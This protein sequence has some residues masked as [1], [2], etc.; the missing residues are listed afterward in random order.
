[1]T[2]PANSRNLTALLGPTNTGKTHLAV[3]RMLA[4]ES[5]MIGLPLRLL[6]REVYDRARLRAGDAAVALVTGE[7]RIVPPSPRYWICTVEAMPPGIDP[8]FLAIDEVQVSTDFERG[9]VFTDRILHRRGRVETMFLGAGTMRPI[10][11]ALLPDAN[12]VTRPRFSKLTYTGQKKLTRLPRRSAIVAFSTET[13]YALAELIRRQR[14]GAAVVL[15]ALSPRTRNAQVALYQSGDVD[16]LV[17]TDAIGMGLNM[18]VDHIAFAATRKFDGF[19]FRSLGPAELGQIA[20]RAGRYVNDGTF[21]VTADA[22]PFDQETVERL[23]NHRFEP[24]RMLQWRNRNLSFKSIDTLKASLGA[25]PDHP[26][27]AR[28]QPGSD[29]IALDLVTGEADISGFIKGPTDVE[30]LWDVCQIPD[31]RNI[32]SA[33][34]AGI[35]GRIFR[36]LGS[37]SRRIDTDWFAR[38]L[39]F[40]ERTDGDID[41]I[42]NRISHVRTW[43]F[44]ANRSGWL[45]DPVHWQNKARQ[46]EDK[47][48]DALHERLTQ[49]FIDRRT[50]VLMKRLNQRESLMST[51]EQDG[52]IHV[53]G[54]YVGHMKGFHFIPDG[55]TGS[56]HERTLKA[57]SLRAVAQEIQTRAQAVAATTDPDLTITADGQIIWQSA[58]IA[59]LEAAASILKPR[60]ALIVGD[61]L[62]GPDRDAVQLRLERWT[63]RHIGALLEPLVKLEDDED[64]AGLARGLAFRLVESLGVLPRDEV[65]EDVKSLSQEE[66][67]GLRKH[68]V[69]FGAFHIFVPALLKPAPTVLRLLLWALW[70]EKQGRF[71]RANLPQPP[72]Q[73]LTSVSFDRSTPKGFYRVV[74]FRLCG[75]RAVRMDMLERLADLIRERV[76]WRPRVEG[77]MRPHGSV[78][79]GGFTIVPDMMSLVGCSGEEFAAIL[80]S[81]GFRMLRRPVPKSQTHT[82]DSPGDAEPAHAASAHAAPA[83]AALQ[84]SPGDADPQTSEETV[85]GAS[86]ELPAA[87]A[88]TPPP[89]G[90]EPQGTEPQSTELQSAAPAPNDA[91]PDAAAREETIEVW[92]PKDTGPFRQQHHQKSRKNFHRSGKANAPDVPLAAKPHKPG[93]PQQVRKPPQ[94][95]KP[96]VNPDSPFAVLGMLRA[97]L[98]E[99]KNA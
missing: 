36:F 99:K 12:F 90:A 94:P 86:P 88:S 83:H 9:H 19:G 4:H 56:A 72:G 10:L 91:A 76:F 33:E 13:V 38:Q 28:A 7:E 32:S 89:Q 25:F 24:V 57:A 93:R 37:G 16:Y 62:N 23:E 54:E 97:Q 87:D 42:S 30:L 65:A 5:G 63:Q 52:A 77:E 17:A 96:A 41:T 47:L 75:P 71:D 18:D 35:V 34:H 51:V 58:A 95:E 74:G 48:S 66:R 49:R 45:A 84:T 82:T 69:R 27:L 46:I 55:A 40:T 98:A 31:Y 22:E 64:L 2:A 60:V 73:G 85:M 1:M 70:L 11:Q 3:E 59:R 78:E 50:S 80:R 79:G 29:M 92:W 6:A 14:G 81:L 26:V 61:Q 67:A 68:G 20:G 8:A 15:G 43:T 21:G 44:V 53:E 39:S